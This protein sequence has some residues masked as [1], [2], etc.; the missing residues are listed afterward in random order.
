LLCLTA[1]VVMLS[2]LISYAPWWAVS[3]AVWDAVFLG[4]Y[5]SGTKQAPIL[6]KWQPK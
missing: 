6:R 5:Y 1:V 2:I 3:V 4:A